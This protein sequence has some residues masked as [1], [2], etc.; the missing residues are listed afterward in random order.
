MTNSREIWDGKDLRR[1]ESTKRVA[2]LGLRRFVRVKSGG[3]PSWIVD[4]VDVFQWIPENDDSL[5]FRGT[6]CIS[7]LHEYC[8]LQRLRTL[9]CQRDFVYLFLSDL[10]PATWTTDS[11]LR[12]VNLFHV[13]FCVKFWC[14]NFL[15]SSVNSFCS[16]VS[17]LSFQSSY[18]F[19]SSSF[20]SLRHSHHAL[21]THSSSIHLMAKYFLHALYWTALESNASMTT[22]VSTDSIQKSLLHSLDH[23]SVS[24]PL[25]TCLG[26][27]VWRVVVCTPFDEI[28]SFLSCRVNHSF[29]Y[30]CLCRPC[31]FIQ[32][33]WFASWILFFS[34]INLSSY[35]RKFFHR[36]S[37]FWNIGYYLFIVD[38]SIRICCVILRTRSTCP[39]SFVNFVHSVFSV[40]LISKWCRRTSFSILWR[41]LRY[42]QIWHFFF[43]VSLPRCD[44]SLK[45]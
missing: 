16:H 26:R 14:S 45:F 31:R 39:I 4:T 15:W 3:N 27:F 33:F 24:V 23:N 18:R 10:T 29:P 34:F 32:S 41:Q 2:D 5:I 43:Y 17:I 40:V 20:S 7:N 12:L 9:S 22:V 44:Q 36:G 25:S 28:I 21:T 35:D 1:T 11:I 38:K 19:L 13:N 42:D 30:L 6:H 37:L 8:Q